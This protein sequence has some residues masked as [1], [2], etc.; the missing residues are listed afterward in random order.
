[1]QLARKSSP[2]LPFHRLPSPTSSSAS[3]STD[4]SFLQL[5]LFRSPASPTIY[6]SLH[7]DLHFDVASNSL[8]QSLSGQDTIHQRHPSLRT[9]P[10]HRLKTGFH[11]LGLTCAAAV[12]C[13]RIR[14][15]LRPILS[16]LRRS[17]LIRHLS[18]SLPSCRAGPLY[19][20]EA[21]T[22]SV[23]SEIRP[24]EFSPAALT[25]TNYLVDELLQLFL[26]AALAPADPTSTQRILQAG[27]HLTTER[28][29]NGVLKVVGTHLGKGCVVEAELSI[30]LLLEFEGNGSSGN[31][32]TSVEHQSISR[33][34]DD[35]GEITAQVQEEAMFRTMRNQIMLLNK[36]QTPSLMMATAAAHLT[37]IDI[38][39]AERC[40]RYLGVYFIRS[41]GRVCERSSCKDVVGLEEVMSALGE[42]NTVWSFIQRMR[43]RSF[44]E[45][46]L[47]AERRNTGSITLNH[48]SSFRRPAR[49]QRIIP[50]SDRSLT[51]SNNTTIGADVSRQLLVKPLPT[52]ASAKVTQ[53]MER[54]NSIKAANPSE[55]CTL[56][57][58]DHSAIADQAKHAMMQREEFTRR[59][60]V[61]MRSDKT[62]KV[63][64]TPTRIKEDV[65]Y[66]SVL[67]C[68]TKT[69]MISY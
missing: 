13:C 14:V 41:F 38:L 11:R 27:E 1:M 49:P 37:P 43:V 63:S 8:G 66:L 62:M 20:S 24:L 68:I 4:G 30:R 67:R 17:L 36:T 31:P 44:I 23:L 25:A 60:E 29:K 40:L 59:F 51:S 57:S 32:D 21:A 18:P 55:V 6:S 45:I 16:H 35:G 10:F 42:N 52:S 64:L 3:G 48:S 69:C 7:I 22:T 15:S 19:F 58:H 56:S 47:A 61:L 12:R 46:E 53:E 5:S 26:H 9:A 2:V 50:L 33:G 65:S 54:R 28:F 39:Y 34:N